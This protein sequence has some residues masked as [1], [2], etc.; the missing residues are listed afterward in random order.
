MSLDL[1]DPKIELRDG[2]FLSIDQLANRTVAIGDEMRGLYVSQFSLDGLNNVYQITSL[3]G[4]QRIRFIHFNPDEPKPYSTLQ[5][6]HI[7]RKNPS[8]GI[9]DILYD[10]KQVS[11]IPFEKLHPALEEIEKAMG[12]IDQKSQE[13]KDINDF[14]LAH[15]WMNKEPALKPLYGVSTTPEERMAK[16]VALGHNMAVRYRCLGGTYVNRSVSERLSNEAHIEV[17]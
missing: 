7:Y 2:I 10:G 11:D 5:I 6:H 12:E 16:A 15:H 17:V 9:C 1:Y 4:K 14:L 3:R 13:C 8:T